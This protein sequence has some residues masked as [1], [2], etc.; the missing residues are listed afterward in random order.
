MCRSDKTILSWHKR[1]NQL[2]KSVLRHFCQHFWKS[3]EK[4]FWFSFLPDTNAT[5]WPDLL[6]GKASTTA[7]SKFMALSSA[8]RS[9][10]VKGLMHCSLKDTVFCWRVSICK[11]GDSCCALL[12]PFLFC[13]WVFSNCFSIVAESG[14]QMLTWLVPIRISG[15]TKAFCC[16]RLQF[17][18][19]C[20][21]TDLCEFSC[22]GGFD[23][24]ECEVDINI[25][26]PH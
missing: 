9:S 10:S 7:R 4:N 2:V 20:H 22:N 25:H 21:H 12:Q 14:F 16:G 13:G 24:F 26:L 8:K 1:T 17:P 18:V 6:S 23:Y 3:V 19:G 15:K 5:R 11:S